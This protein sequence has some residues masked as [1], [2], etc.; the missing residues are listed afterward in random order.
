M[1]VVYGRMQPQVRQREGQS[2]LTLLVKVSYYLARDRTCTERSAAVARKPSKLHLLLLDALILFLQMVLATIAY[3]ASL[4]SKSSSSDS[5]PLT[6]STNI[7]DPS[8]PFP[9]PSMSASSTPN[10]DASPS[11]SP[12][13]PDIIDPQYIIDLRLSHILDRL[14]NPTPTSI[15]PDSLLPLPNTSPWP[16][17]AS[18]RMLLRARAEVRRRAQAQLNGGRNENRTEDGNGIRTGGDTSRRIPGAM[19]TEDAG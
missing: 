2:F 11:K 18:L 12:P 16:V 15:D 6:S 1:S 14:K 8:S 9:F 19:D 10:L 17:P 5:I 4:I 3:E 13:P 7:P